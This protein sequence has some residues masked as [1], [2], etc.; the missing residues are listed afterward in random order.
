MREI[1]KVAVIGSGVMGAGIAAHIANSGTEVLL[2]DIVP[3]DAKNRNMLAEG[4]IEKIKKMKP[5]AIT[6]PRKLKL[7]TAGNLED[8]LPRLKEADWIIEVVI[9]K[10]E[11][12][13]EVYRKVNNYR[14]ER[15]IVSSNTSTIPL[16]ELTDGMSEEFKRDFLITHF[17]NPPRYMRLL[18]LV[19]GPSTRKD[20]A[21]IIRRFAD[22]NLGKGVVPCKD[23]PG[24][25]A[26]RIGVFW[27]EIAM[28]EAMRLGLTV[29]E[30][31]SVMGK[32]I[33][34]PKTGVFGLMD[35]IGIDL[36]PLIAKEMFQSLPEKDTFRVIYKE[37]EIV[38][39]MIKEGYTGRKGKGGFYRLNTD[40]GKKSKEVADLKTGAY[41]AEAKPKLESV[42]KAK[43]GL[44]ALVEHPD[45]GG[46]F[47]RSVLAQML[48]YTASLVPEISD[49]ILG[50]DEAMRLGYNW[51]YGPFELID[52]LG[53]KDGESGPAY[54]AKMLKEKN[55][56]VPAIVEAVG[57]GTFYKEEGGKRTYFDGN[58]GYSPIV[59]PEGCYMLADYK[60][61]KKPI[62]KN[63]SASLWDLGD[64]VVGLE[65]N[66]KMNTF[67]PLILELI[68]QSVDII[69]KDFKALVIGNDADNFSVGANIGILLF[70][71]NCA[72][73]KT[74]DGII[75][76]GQDAFMALKY[77]PFPV[78]GA[79]SGMALGG[80]CEVLLHCDAVQA[81]IETYAGLVE[82]G[83]GLIPGW[84]GCKEM[85]VRHV[86]QRQQEETLAAKMG[87]M[88]SFISPIKALNTMPAVTKAFEYIATAKVGESA[89]HIKDML[90]LPETYGITMNRARVLSDAKALALKLAR[91]YQPPTPPVIQLPGRTAR[92]ALH[93]AIS[94]FVK[95]GKATKH[96]EVVSKALA[97]VLSGGDTDISK[98]LTEQNLLD[99]EREVF[100][101]LV[102][103]PD[104]MARIEHMLDTGKPLRN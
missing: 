92:T 54:F 55:I 60:R 35:L 56:P 52:R 37:P 27:L 33:G 82:V 101:D 25:I 36:L 34:V 69:K 84:G 75:K 43:D 104:T 76:Q 50:V 40:G 2:L 97:R 13:K 78:V 39:T 89:D 99:L 45:N 64:G 18:E 61:G 62:K 88:F 90:I 70:V 12:K 94:G 79:P 96:D 46:Q 41:R 103:H 29:E 86:R 38:T 21:E 98:P 32:P 47:A 9:E 22:V 8:D 67:D 65:F 15:A 85:L 28:L 72:A 23:T 91:G 80:G 93:M 73:W 71:A 14:K 48:A 53:T 26:N 5:A 66:S 44:R 19:V 81:H 49:S 77:A 63:P 87:G 10:L 51:K 30:A 20:T 102:R 7:I 83:V 42:E 17:F 68:T 57:S 11:V 24:F 6:H 100:V 95:S 74:V 4:A 58:K 31:D 1:K 59:T 16:H 3:K